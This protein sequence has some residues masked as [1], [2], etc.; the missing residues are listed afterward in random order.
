MCRA[1][2]L[3]W[4]NACNYHLCLC[5]TFNSFYDFLVAIWL[6]LRLFALGII[7]KQTQRLLA[8]RHSQVKNIFMVGSR[9]TFQEKSAPNVDDC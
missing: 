2:A 7:S 6:L 4:S 9:Y 3:S 8:T 1:C 5:N